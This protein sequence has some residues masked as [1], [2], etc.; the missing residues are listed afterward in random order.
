[1]NLKAQ[2]TYIVENTQD[3]I[4]FKSVFKVYQ[5]LIGPSAVTLFGYLF[6]QDKHK[7][8]LTHQELCDSLRTIQSY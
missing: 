4:D 2:D 3:F 8:A 6:Y 1:M 5:R 7:N